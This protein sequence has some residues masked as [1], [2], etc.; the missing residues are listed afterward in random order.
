MYML[1]H[2][3]PSLFFDVSVSIF[4]IGEYTECPV[5][6]LFK[7][8]LYMTQKHEKVNPAGAQIPHG[9]ELHVAFKF[10]PNTTH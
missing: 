4:S 10:I 5:S 8:S 7:G 9:A 3:F 1:V 6:M 2:T